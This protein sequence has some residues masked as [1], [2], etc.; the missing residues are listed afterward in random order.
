MA[1]LGFTLGD[2]AQVQLSGSISSAGFGAIDQGPSQRNQEDYKDYAINAQLKLDKF[3]PEDWGME[4]PV[5]ITMSEQY[6][7][8]KYNT[9]TKDNINYVDTRGVH[10]I[11]GDILHVN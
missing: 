3:L 9:P 6:S 2:F 4:I 7:V 1:S 11:Y 10:M 8:K 5:N